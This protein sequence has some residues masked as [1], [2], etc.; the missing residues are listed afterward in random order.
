MR[1][2]ATARFSRSVPAGTGFPHAGR[3]PSHPLRIVGV[4]RDLAQRKPSPQ[5]SGRLR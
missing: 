4:L 3:T 1:R 2:S 5:P